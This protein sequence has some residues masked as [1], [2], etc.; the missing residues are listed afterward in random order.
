MEDTQHCDGRQADS[1]DVEI[2][3]DAHGRATNMVSRGDHPLRKELAHLHDVLSQLAPPASSTVDPRELKALDRIGNALSALAASTAQKDRRRQ[4]REAE[5]AAVK[6]RLEKRRV[7]LEVVRELAAEIIRHQD[8]AQRRDAE[9]A[10]ATRL[11]ERTRRAIWGSPLHAGEE[12]TVKVDCAAVPA[13]VAPGAFL[14]LVRSAALAD[15]PFWA[16]ADRP[17]QIA[18]TFAPPRSF[19]ANNGHLVGSAGA[20]R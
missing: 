19:M 17:R 14:E 9:R 6:A 15:A 18:F 20:G 12:F 3:R 10:A 4:E 8:A 2:K 13:L 5:R 1:W 16:A 11:W 7:L